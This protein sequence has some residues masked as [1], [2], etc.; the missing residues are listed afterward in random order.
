MHIVAPTEVVLSPPAPPGVSPPASFEP[1]TH[2]L[3]PGS[4]RYKFSQVFGPTVSQADFFRCTALPLV[5]E[6]LNGKSGL[7]FAYG[8]TASGKTYTVQGGS[9]GDDPGILPRSMD[10]V[11]NSV[12]P[13]QTDQ[14]I[15][16]TRLNGVE[17]VSPAEMGG[18]HRLPGVRDLR[19]QLASSPTGERDSSAF[20]LDD[21]SEYSV[22]VSVAEIYNEKVYDLLDSCTVSPSSSS[23]S[24]HSFTASL[25]EQV[26]QAAQH[27]QKA[28]TGS[29]SGVVKRKAL[30][31]KHDRSNG[32]K[33]ISGLTELRVWSAEEAK[34]LL[35][36]GQINRSVFSTLAN[37]T[38]SRSHSIVTIRVIRLPK[39]SP[40]ADP[41]SL[42]P[43]ATVSRLSVVDL[44][45]S[46]RTRNTGTTGERLKEAG[47]INKSLMV[48]GQC[49][50]VLRRNQDLRSRHLASASAPL[51]PGK[52]AVVPF[53]HSKLT[54]LFQSFFTVGGAGG[55]RAVMIVNA[56]PSET[57]F[58]EN[59]HV[60]KFSAVASEV[61]TTRERTPTPVAAPI[62][63]SRLE[64]GGGGGLQVPAA[65]LEQTSER[66]IV[67]EEGSLPPLLRYCVCSY[68]STDEDEDSDED[69]AD[70]F[71]DHLLD[72]LSALRVKVNASRHCQSSE[73]DGFVQMVEAE[74]RA[75]MIEAEVRER[76][77][78]EMS[79]QIQEMEDA[80][81]VRLASEV[82]PAV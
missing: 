70:V 43:H 22:W 32:H 67:V 17:L 24:L 40:S 19:N 31:L 73:A 68:R 56:N 14:P 63:G 60:M 65:A 11:F 35:R 10:A 47:N 8:V 58:D 49:M 52:L 39:S 27:L 78:K 21:G 37:R 12:G 13:R 26:K 71:V 5:G 72:Q 25:A 77:M 6:L 48:L 46:E 51:A 7:C 2:A 79:V 34:S 15:R 42:L 38:S 28:A 76:V 64:L 57:G 81:A 59:M 16:P 62:V 74:I 4:A 66:S 80:Y 1:S 45:G 82:R 75:T 3:E 44:A 55:G 41:A 29:A 18:R 36:K 61:A 69:D 20:A 9:H 54:E 23:S 53:R 50:E 30:S 33:Y